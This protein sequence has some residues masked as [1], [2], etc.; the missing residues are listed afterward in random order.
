M[1]CLAQRSD[2]SWVPLTGCVCTPPPPP[3]SR[4]F[5]SHPRANERS[6]LELVLP[7]ALTGWRRHALGTEGRALSVRRSVCLSGSLSAPTL[8]DGG[9]TVNAIA[10]ASYCEAAAITKKFAAVARTSGSE[11]KSDLSSVRTRQ[12]NGDPSCSQLNI[13]SSYIGA[14]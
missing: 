6:L 3:P 7:P 9:A 4:R 12:N 2:I 1:N 11:N 8:G 10:F 14:R 13:S 5:P